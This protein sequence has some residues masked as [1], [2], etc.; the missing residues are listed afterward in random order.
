MEFLWL[1]K[2]WVSK[3]LQGTIPA[4]GLP[5]FVAVRRQGTRRIGTDLL[6]TFCHSDIA[7]NSSAPMSSH[8]LS[9]NDFVIRNAGI[10]RSGKILRSTE[11]QAVADSGGCCRLT[12][13]KSVRAVRIHYAPSSHPTTPVVVGGFRQAPKLLP[14]GS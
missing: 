11:F 4:R 9:R 7:S 2:H 8:C 5:P 6:S 3:H 14:F 1:L 12:V 10:P 13:R